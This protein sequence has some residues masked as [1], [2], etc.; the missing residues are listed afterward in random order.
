MPRP[1]GILSGEIT[2][3]YEQLVKYLETAA[4]DHIAPKHPAKK[5][6]YISD[7]TYEH[8]K[9]KET[10]KKEGRW[11]ELEAETKE[12][13]KIIKVKKKAY[14]EETMS[15]NLD[16][17]DKWLGIKNIKQQF[18]PKMYERAHWN[19][20]AKICSKE[21]KA[22]HAGSYLEHKQWGHLLHEGDEFSLE[23]LLNEEEPRFFVHNDD[24]ENEFNLGPIT[25]DELTRIIKTL[26]K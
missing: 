10:L 7:E 21:E 4:E 12:L 24:I 13:K 23:Y 8:I 2:E 5:R 20:N 22:E 9:N 11:T 16:E 6:D 26:F 15:S 19:D 1:G 17:R 25:V 18:C 3:Q 14:I